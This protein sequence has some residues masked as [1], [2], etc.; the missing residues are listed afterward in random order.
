MLRIHLT[1]AAPHG[2]VWQSDKAKTVQ[3]TVCHTNIRTQYE[4][5]GLIYLEK[6]G[7]PFGAHELSIDE[8]AVTS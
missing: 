4:G 3:C 6:C 8:D 2:V 7:G 5:N 1:I